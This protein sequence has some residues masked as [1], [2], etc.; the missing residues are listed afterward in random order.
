MIDDPLL[1][2]RLRLAALVADALNSIGLAQVAL[3]GLP[4]DAPE[5][6]QW[7][8]LVVAA[9]EL[10]DAAGDR[11]LALGRAP[12]VASAGGH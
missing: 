1:L 10:V 3:N 4:A 11:L 7:Q 9:L 2:E 5:R 8:G 12:D 6:V